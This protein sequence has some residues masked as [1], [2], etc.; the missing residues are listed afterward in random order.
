MHMITINNV[1]C[2]IGHLHISSLICSKHGHHQD[3]EENHNLKLVKSNV[4]TLYL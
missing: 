2:D 4:K 1:T 3:Y